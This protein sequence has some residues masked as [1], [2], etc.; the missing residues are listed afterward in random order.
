MHDRDNSQYKMLTFVITN[1]YNHYNLIFK[2]ITLRG[3]DG[4]DHF[5]TVLSLLKEEIPIQIQGNT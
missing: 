3:L 1:H 4:R 2:L 5:T